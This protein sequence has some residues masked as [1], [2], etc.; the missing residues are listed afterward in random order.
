[1]FVFSN[2]M[3]AESIYLHHWNPWELRAYRVCHDFMDHYLSYQRYIS[4]SFFVFLLKNGQCIAVSLEIDVTCL[5]YVFLSD[6]SKWVQFNYCLSINLFP[7]IV[8]QFEV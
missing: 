6:T 2:G 1:M 3:A 8:I 5:L 7:E 4:T